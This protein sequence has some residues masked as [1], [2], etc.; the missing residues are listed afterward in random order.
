VQTVLLILADAAT[1]ASVADTAIARAAEDG[2][3]L[4]VLSILDR[5]AP[6]EM[7]TRL[8]DSGTMGARPSV[9]VLESLNRR[10]DVLAS[11][12]SDEVV[13]AAAGRGVK[14]RSEVRRGRFGQEIS[15]FL[16]TLHPEVVVVEKRRRPLL[17]PR[18]NETLLDKLG[19]TLGFEL[20]E[21]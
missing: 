13:A 1:P 17:L 4:V 21:A 6:T 12:R 9:E 7:A 20:V 11:E 18:S 10:R 15:E 19:R 2:R 16:S 14:V 5:E 3:E 8:L